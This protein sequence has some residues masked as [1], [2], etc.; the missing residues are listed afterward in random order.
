MRH[1]DPIKFSAFAMV[2]AHQ[3]QR[4]RCH[5]PMCSGLASSSEVPAKNAPEVQRKFSHLATR[6]PLRA[7]LR[8]HPI[9][10]VI[11][12]FQALLARKVIRFCSETRMCRFC[13]IVPWFGW[14]KPR[15][16]AATSK[17]TQSPTADVGRHVTSHFEAPDKRSG[18]RTCATG[19]N[20]LFPERFDVSSMLGM[21][22]QST[23]T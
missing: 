2:I 18:W 9:G 20:T 10:N 11:H 21:P 17:R 13:F 3:P 19:R 15:F 6:R 16:V 12:Q 1:S 4:Y 8:L 14:P 7:G 22:F 23:K 5:N